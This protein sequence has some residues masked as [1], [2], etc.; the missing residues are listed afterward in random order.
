MT[1]RDLAGDGWIIGGAV[2]SL[3]ALAFSLLRGNRLLGRITSGFAAAFLEKWSD[4]RLEKQV[5]DMLA[6][7]DAGTAGE[8]P[9]A[10]PGGL[11][12]RP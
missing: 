7:A 2:A 6:K 12:S 10:G 1:R 4:M 9:E 11:R 5:A 8:T 3:A